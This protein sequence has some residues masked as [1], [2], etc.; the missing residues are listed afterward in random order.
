MIVHP[1]TGEKLDISSTAGRSVFKNYLKYFNTG[2]ESSNIS[3]KSGNLTAENLSKF[4][5]ELNEEFKTKVGSNVDPTKLEEITG[6]IDGFSS[7]LQNYFTSQDSKI[8]GKIDEKISDIQTK[9]DNISEIDGK[10][11][12]KINSKISEIDGKIGKIGEIDSKISGLETKVSKIGEIDNKINS[13]ISEKLEGIPNKDEL[14]K[15]DGKINNVIT[16]LEGKD[17]TNYFTNDQAKNL[18]NRLNVITNKINNTDHLVNLTIPK[19]VDKSDFESYKKEIKQ[20]LETLKDTEINID[21]LNDILEE[22]GL[23]EED[24]ESYTAKKQENS[25]EDKKLRSMLLEGDK[26]SNKIQNAIDYV[27]ERTAPFKQLTGAAGTTGMDAISAFVGGANS[28]TNRNPRKKILRMRTSN[29]STD[30]LDTYKKPLTEVK[31]S[32]LLSGG[33][34]KFGPDGKQMSIPDIVTELN[35]IKNTGKKGDNEAI[36]RIDELESALNDYGKMVMALKEQVDI[37]PKSVLNKAQKDYLINEIETKVKNKINNQNS[38]SQK[39]IKTLSET[40]KLLKDRIVE[41]ERKLISN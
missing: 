21:K 10:I 7:E 32:E 40:F 34:M 41:L 19:I 22:Y 4:L 6:K 33:R 11:D 25:G 9:V 31:L 38:Q 39:R 17:L 2:G 1:V 16:Q 35:T 18:Q 8:D 28:R 3:V 20:K 15:I 27:K 29:L 14:T 23:I 24:G 26:L 37:T 5:A 30:P 36:K 13:K 12:S